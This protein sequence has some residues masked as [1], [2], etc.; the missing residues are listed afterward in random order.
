[1]NTFATIEAAERQAQRDQSC[2]FLSG[3]SKVIY[4]NGAGEY[5]LVCDSAYARGKI[6][7]YVDR[8]GKVSRE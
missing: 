6:V 8:N 5:V 2:G 3:P 1:M 7:S 4:L